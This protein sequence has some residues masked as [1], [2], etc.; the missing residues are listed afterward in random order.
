MPE[1]EGNSDADN[2]GGPGSSPERESGLEQWMPPELSAALMTMR[3]Q[4]HKNWP[5]LAQMQCG[6]ST[7]TSGSGEKERRQSDVTLSAVLAVLNGEQA[8]KEGGSAEKGAI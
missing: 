3:G 7:A 2:Q 1:A 4:V 5:G 8:R 6:A